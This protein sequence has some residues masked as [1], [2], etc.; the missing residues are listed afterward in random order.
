MK[1][2]LETDNYDLTIIDNQN[3]SLDTSFNIT[4][5]DEL[6]FNIVYS[7][8]NCGFSDGSITSNIIGGSGIYF[9]DWDNDG[10]GDN[11]DNPSLSGLIAG[12]YTLFLSDDVGCSKDTSV[13]I[14]NTTG[15]VISIDNVDSVSCFGGSD[16]NIS[17]SVIGG[18]SPYTY[19]WNPSVY[20]QNNNV[21]NLS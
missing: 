5:N 6:L 19:L 14:S 12:T 1:K 8:A 10:V 17:A 7:D 11:D 20:S 15:P 13:I 4:S 2:R 21:T 9:Y 18:T 3:C 16:G